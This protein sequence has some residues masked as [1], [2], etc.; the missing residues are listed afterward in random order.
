MIHTVR[1][2]RFTVLHDF[3]HDFEGKHV[4]I[5]GKNGIGKSSIQKFIRIALG[6]KDC[7]APG[8]EIEG[9]VYKN[10]L[11]K[12]YKFSVKMDKGKP[13]VTVTGPDGMSDSRVGV[14]ASITGAM[15]FN[16]TE[17]IEMSKSDKGRKTQV[18]IFK[19]FFPKEII[20]GIEKMEENVRVAFEDRTQ[21]NKDIKLKDTEVKTNPMDIHMDKTLDTFKEVDISGAMAELKTLQK[22]NTQIEQVR[23]NYENR[24]QEIYAEQ[25]AID[26]LQKKL[27]AKKKLQEQADEWLKNNK[28]QNT[29]GLESTIQNATKSNQE[30]QNAQKLKKDRA[31]LAKMVDESET[32]TVNIE[33]QREAIRIAIKDMT[34]DLVPGLTFN[35][36]GLVYN[37]LPVHPDTHSTS[38]RIKLGMRMKIAQNQEIGVLFLENLESVDEDGMKMIMELADEIGM[39]IIGEEVRRG[40]KDMVFEII[41]E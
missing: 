22:T 8:V 15:N 17:F 7:I 27:D 14:I 23:A 16:I 24:A 41:G 10:H 37:D 13:K 12:E 25:L 30:F 40:E 35:E 2:N 19:S 29:D 11:G 21:L 32:A 28:I 4:L 31:L 39:Q 36:N 26:E 6:E 5:C 34:T 18:E 1:I 38:E 9:E 20:D 33:S 3:Q